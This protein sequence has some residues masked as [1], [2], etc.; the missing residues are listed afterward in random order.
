ME[1]FRSA[2]S[3]KVERYGV[4]AVHAARF[5]GR[6]GEIAPK[7]SRAV[8]EVAILALNLAARG[9]IER[10]AAHRAVRHF[11]LGLTS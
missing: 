8:Q 7:A 9:F 5:L 6:F 1:T 11:V 3:D 10:F 4:P 2:S